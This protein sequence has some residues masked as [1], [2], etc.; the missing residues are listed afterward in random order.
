MKVNI[1][2]AVSSNYCIGKNNGLVLTHKE[3][4]EYFKNMTKDSVVLM[5]RK[6][7]ESLGEKP[8][9][10]RKNYYITNNK[11]KIKLK[12]VIET[13]KSVYKTVTITEVNSLKEVINFIHGMHLHKNIW[14]IGGGSVYKQSLEE[15]IVDEVYITKWNQKIDGDTFFPLLNEDIWFRKYI[16]HPLRTCDFVFETW[17]KR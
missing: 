11:G 12:T 15:D 7:W 16:T 6:T 17:Q 3:D 2:T 13:Q 9:K 14:V 1:I 8:L 5:G 10:G 4:F